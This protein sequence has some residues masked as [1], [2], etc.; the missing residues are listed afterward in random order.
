MF[1]FFMFWGAS[2]WTLLFLRYSVYNGPKMG[3]VLGPQTLIVTLFF[4]S[5]PMGLPLASFGVPFWFPSCSPWHPSGSLWLHLGSL[6]VPFWFPSCSPWHPFGS[7]WVPFGTMLVPSGSLWH[8]WGTKSWY[9]S[10][11]ASFW[12]PFDSFCYLFWW[13]L[14]L[15]GAML[16]NSMFFG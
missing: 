14:S 6:L 16:V 12:R 7:L 11:G 15:R 5:V 13:Y 1:Y 4:D 10:A 8:F 9:F 3:Y 2:I